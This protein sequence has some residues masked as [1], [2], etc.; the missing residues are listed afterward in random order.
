MYLIVKL[1]MQGLYRSLSLCL[2]MVMFGSTVER[3]SAGVSV[4]PRGDVTSCPRPGDP[5]P[6]SHPAQ[7]AASHVA[8]TLAAGRP[9]GV[10][11]DAAGGGRTLATTATDTRVVSESAG[12]PWSQGAGGGP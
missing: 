10:R 6:A 8:A 12:P 2:F 1:N 4:P 3:L 9:L 5:G 11:G 7:W